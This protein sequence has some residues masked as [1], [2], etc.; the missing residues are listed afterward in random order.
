[1]LD[2]TR[3]IAALARAI[4]LALAQAAEAQGKAVYLFCTGTDSTWGG[5]LGLYSNTISMA[6]GYVHGK[7]FSETSSSR[8]IQALFSEG[9]HIS[10]APRMV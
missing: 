3:L 5:S 10:R 1:M 4:F 7:L 6:D 2:I 9:S 8:T